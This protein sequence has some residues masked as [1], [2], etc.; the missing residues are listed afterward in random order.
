M[1]PEERVTRT[2]VASIVYPY[3]SN[4]VDPLDEG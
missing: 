2:Y 4:H 3:F 1:S